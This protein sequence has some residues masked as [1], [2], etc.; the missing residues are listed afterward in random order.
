MPPVEKIFRLSAFPPFRT[1]A[2][3]PA[4]PSPVGPTC[5]RPRPTNQIPEDAHS[6]TLPPA[7][8]RP[9]GGAK[10]PPRFSARQSR[11]SNTPARFSHPGERF[12]V[13]EPRL[14]NPEPRYS[15]TGARLSRAE[16]RFSNPDT[17]FSG[18]ESRYPKAAP[19]FSIP[20]SRLSRTGSRYSATALRFSRTSLR[21]SGTEYLKSVAENLS[22]STS[23]TYLALFDQSQP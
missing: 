12:S 14:S 17:R 22:Y 18:K 15:G 10:A 6:A 11:C 16:A 13:S 19:R 9:R 4:A 1:P 3:T 7:P 21:Y 5:G 8:V 23:W 2:R 20:S